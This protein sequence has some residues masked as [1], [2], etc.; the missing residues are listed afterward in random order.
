MALKD[1][2]VYVDNSKANAKRIDA[3]IR[4]AAEHDAHLTGLYVT[5]DSTGAPLYT[6]AHTPPELLEAQKKAV[7]ERAEEAEQRFKHAVDRAGLPSEWR[8]GEGDVTRTL[9]LHARYVDLVIIGQADTSDHLSPS[10]RTVE[11]MVLDV[12]RPVLVV[13]YIGASQTIGRRIVVAWNASREAIRAIHDAMPLLERADAVH[14]LSI[15]PSRG[16]GGDGD[17]PGGDIAAHLARHNIKVEAS[18]TEADDI[19]VGEML[20]SR[21]SDHGAD[22]LVMGAYGHSRYRELVLGG[23]T[24]ELLEAMTVPVLMSH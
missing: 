4:L 1:L 3:A 6:E 18:Y 9:S 17:V 15:T 14:V 19:A 5:P 10:P 21:I 7:Q 11:Q 8:S 20:L 23:A 24:H 2:L 22:L 12:G 16:R 13:P